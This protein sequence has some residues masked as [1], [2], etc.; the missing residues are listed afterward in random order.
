MLQSQQIAQQRF[1]KER[2]DLEQAHLSVVKH[3]EIKLKELDVANKV[4]IKVWERWKSE[5][6]T[7]YYT[8]IQPKSYYCVLVY[9]N[10]Y[11]Y[12]LVINFLVSCSFP[13]SKLMN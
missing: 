2:R 12:S 11:V 7:V 8:N 6:Y 13:N 5:V 4:C 1:D 3:L 9:C 10:F